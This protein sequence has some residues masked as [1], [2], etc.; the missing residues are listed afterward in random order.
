[1]AQVPFV[2]VKYAANVSSTKSNALGM[3]TMQECA[4]D[5]HREIVRIIGL[6]TNDAEGK[7]HASPI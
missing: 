1:M 6:A 3:H 5:K 7:T 2:S 4:Y